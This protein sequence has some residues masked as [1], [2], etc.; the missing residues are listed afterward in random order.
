MKWKKGDSMENRPETE[1]PPKKR[2]SSVLINILLAVCILG[3]VVSVIG[4]VYTLMRYKIASD[5]YTDL[6][7]YAQTTQTEEAGERVIDL[8]ALRALNPDTIGWLEI[9]GTDI[10]YPLLQGTDNQYYLQYTFNNTQNPSGAIYLDWECKKDFSQVNS[11]IYGHHMKDG[12]MFA[13]LAEYMDDPTYRAGHGEVHIYTDEG[14]RIYDVI[15]AKQVTTSDDEMRI[16]FEDEN[17]EEAWLTSMGAQ[18]GDSVVTLITCVNSYE[19]SD[20]RYVLQA[21]LRDIEPF[22]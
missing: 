22:K 20:D 6:R 3:V 2:K 11:L 16:A 12:S 13:G 21:A 14:K 9:P 15:G 5:E 1:A 17:A 10:D 7:Q 19:N 4:L 8:D 18:P